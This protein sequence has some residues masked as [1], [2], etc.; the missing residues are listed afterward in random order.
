MQINETY[1]IFGGDA[2][3]VH[4]CRGDHVEVIDVEGDQQCAVFAFDVEGSAGG[5]ILT[6]QDKSAINRSEVVRKD[7][8]AKLQEQ[9]NQHKIM[10]EQLLSAEIFA[11]KTT[12]AAH[13]LFEVNQDGLCVFSAHGDRMLVSEQN[14]LTEILIHV[15]RIASEVLSDLPDPLA[16]PLHDI[17]IDKATARSYVVKKGEYIQIIDVEGHQCSDFQ[18][19]SLHDINQGI[20][21]HIQPTVTRS[22]TQL[23]CPEPGV[24]SKF[25]DKDAQPLVEI[26][27]DKVMRHDMLGLA[28]NAKYYEDRGFPGHVNCTDN[29]N[30]ALAGQSLRTTSE[31]LMADL[32]CHVRISP[33]AEP[34]TSKANTAHC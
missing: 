24:H 29:F 27:H 25:Y 23:S 4:V 34:S 1:Q 11:G 8:P 33:P 20:E 3:A 5:D 7:C 15:S 2:V 31:R 9:L 21:N 19:F 17:R 12:A 16:T 26:V 28:C 32:S 6:W 13:R 10:Q 14:A 30:K 18:A 22:L